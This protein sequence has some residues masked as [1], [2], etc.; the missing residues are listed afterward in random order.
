[1]LRILEEEREIKY[2]EQSCSFVI[3]YSALNFLTNVTFFKNIL[4]LG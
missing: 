3:Y 4:Y 1:M 2:Y